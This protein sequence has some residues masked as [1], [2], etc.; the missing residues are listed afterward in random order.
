MSETQDEGFERRQVFDTP[1]PIILST[2]H[3][4]IRKRCTCGKLNAGTFPKEA[5]APAS[6]GPNVRAATLYLLFGQHLS[7]ERTADAMSTML[8]AQVSTGF[9]ASLAKEAAGGLTGFIDVIRRRLSSSFLVHAD[10]T[11]D[12]VRTDKWW[13]HVVSNELYTYLFASPTRAKSA[14]DEAGV[15]PEFAASW[16]TTA[17]PCTS[18]TTTRPTQSAWHTSFVSWSR[19][20]SDGT[21]DG[22]TTWRHLLRDEQ[23]GAR[24]P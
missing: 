11:S 22:P 4:S 2:E 24:R 20:G 5:T 12:Q 15:L 9:V 23:G 17:S 1:D 3:R 18:S 13:F 6:Y 10:E 16:C 14:P 7:V 19:S 21:R 8:G